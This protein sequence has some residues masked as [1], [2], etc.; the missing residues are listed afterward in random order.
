MT[1]ILSYGITSD[2]SFGSANEDDLVPIGI[3]FYFRETIDITEDQ[4]PFAKPCMLFKNASGQDMTK[5]DPVSSYRT[6]NGSN[7]EVTGDSTVIYKG[8]S[9]ANRFKT[10]E[11]RNT[12]AFSSSTASKWYKGGMEWTS[13]GSTYK[14]T[15]SY[16]IEVIAYY[17]TSPSVGVPGYLDYYMFVCSAIDSIS[18]SYVTGKGYYLRRTY[19]DDGLGNIVTTDVVEK[20]VTRRARIFGN[21][22][23]SATIINMTGKLYKDSVYSHTYDLD[24]TYNVR[25]GSSFFISGVTEDWIGTRSWDWNLKEWRLWYSASKVGEVIF[26]TNPLRLDQMPASSSYASGSLPYSEVKFTQNPQNPGKADEDSTTIDFNSSA[27]TWTKKNDNQFDLHIRGTIYVMGSAK[28]NIPNTTYNRV[29][30]YP[31]LAGRWT[32][33]DLVTTEISLAYYYA[34]K[35]DI[36]AKLM[37]GY[38]NP[39]TYNTESNRYL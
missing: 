9:Y 21:K 39:A 24:D 3:D 5:Y 33:L 20:N 19:T 31:E 2:Y 27:Y 11:D 35:K 37:V 12:G 34:R 18:P 36:S 16:P 22:I 25:W 32:Y 7:Y 17:D 15:S 23:N 26:S 8:T 6:Y 13:G 28:E 14:I 1:N 4:I 29:Y 10:E 38:N 30:S